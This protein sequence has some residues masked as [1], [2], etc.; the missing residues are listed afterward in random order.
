M[1]IT[2]NDSIRLLRP[3]ASLSV[4]IGRNI[5]IPM[6]GVTISGFVK[7]VTQRMKTLG[8]IYGWLF[9]DRGKIG[10]AVDA[11]VIFRISPEPDGPVYFGN[12]F[13][14]FSVTFVGQ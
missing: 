5:S 11:G 3:T 1:A 10:F 13:V 4:A 12:V 2:G 8:R 9:I 7:T 6:V 14:L